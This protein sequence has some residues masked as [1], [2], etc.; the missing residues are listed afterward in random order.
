MKKLM[1]TIW[2]TWPIT[3][4]PTAMFKK[5][6]TK[7][8]VRY[9][10]PSSYVFLC[11]QTILQRMLYV[12]V[13]IFLFVHQVIEPQI[14]MNDSDDENEEGLIIDP[15]EEEEEENIEVKSFQQQDRKVGV[16]FLDQV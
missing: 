16:P 2:T 12:Y 1:M 7:W 14:I 5:T 9:L 11:D 4:E 13:H 15:S 6:Q 8:L 10:R 3:K